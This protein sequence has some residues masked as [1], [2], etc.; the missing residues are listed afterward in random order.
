MKEDYSTLLG[1]IITIGSMMYLDKNKDVIEVFQLDTNSRRNPT[2]N[3]RVI[4]LY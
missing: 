3:E 4:L 2:N 1:G